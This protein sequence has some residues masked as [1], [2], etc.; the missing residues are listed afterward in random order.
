M[1][2]RVQH[3]RGT[4]SEVNAITLKSGELVVDTSRK[5]LR[6]GDGVT[7]GG[8]AA[9]RADLANV[10]AATTSA[11]GKMSAAQVT[12]LDA[13][14][15]GVATNAGD[16][17]TN[18]AAIAQNANDISSL[19]SATTSALSGKQPVDALLTAIAALT[20]AA[21]KLIYTTGSDAVALTGLSSFARTLLDDASAS[22]ARSTL[23]LAIGTNVQAQDA[24]LTALAGLTSAADK[25]P[26]FTGSGTAALATLTS[27]MRTLLDDTD[28]ST[29]RATLGLTIGSAVQAYSATL[30]ALAALSTTSF[31]RSLLEA[32]N[33]AAGR[34]L[35]GLGSLAVLSAINN[36]NWSGADLAVT[37]GGTGASD[38]AGAR[39]NLGLGSLA[40]A[41]SIN[42][43]NWSGTDLAVANGGTGG[44]DVA[45]ARGNLGVPT[46]SIKIGSTG[47][48][49]PGA[50][51]DIQINLGA[52]YN[53]PLW[54]VCG[55][56]GL[57]EGEWVCQS[58]F[59]S[60]TGSYHNR[61][62]AGT[63]AAVGSIDS[64]GQPTP[65]GANYLALRIFNGRA[66]S[67]V[68][69]YRVVILDFGTA[70]LN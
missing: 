51:Q 63:S 40:T 33:A 50:W 37:N 60:S 47:S 22:A 32:A 14:T 13:A 44:S 70:T 69:S 4:T 45:T 68:I 15:S 39:S 36:S 52:N 18:A 49:A 10:S 21:D 17:A 57:Q 7:V 23:G 34:T 31:G 42:N 38:A 59:R 54:F 56:D 5:E 2:K 12:Q 65:T 67:S 53:T 3:I 24:E 58:V 43:A 61:M 46:F 8:V 28:A 62:D 9:A 29:A 55:H 27:F 6:V 30:A 64:T 25:V 19:D 26:Y 1:S 41:S 66:G 11:A 20:T 48:L 35:F 16:I